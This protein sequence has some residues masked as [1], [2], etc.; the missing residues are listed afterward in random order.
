MKLLSR[1][2]LISVATA[3]AIAAGSLSTPAFATEETKGSSASDIKSIFS[4]SSS[5]DTETTTGT[6]NTT[7]KKSTEKILDEVKAWVGIISAVIGVLTTILTFSG[8]IDRLFK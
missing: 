6:S 2:A 7:S 5:T 4:S 1:K 3:T 8:K